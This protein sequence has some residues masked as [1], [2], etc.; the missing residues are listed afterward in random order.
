MNRIRQLRQERHL[1][2]GGL[3]MHLNTS[4]ST[5]SLYETGDRLPDMK[6]CIQLA[7]FFRV[8][9]DFLAGYSDVRNPEA[10]AQMTDL[11]YNIL[12]QL[13]SLDE[14]KQRQVDAFIKGLRM[15]SL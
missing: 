6:T 12:S 3:A 8:S 14:G 5:I 1:N 4:Q 7:E 13:Q 11:E 9:L 2:Q 10:S 15:G